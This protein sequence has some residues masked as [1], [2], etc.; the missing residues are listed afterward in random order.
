MVRF[1][2]PGS[3]KNPSCA[4]HGYTLI[5]T[6]IVLIIISLVMASLL[7]SFNLY[8]KTQERIKTTA[9]I[10]TAVQKIND[11]LVRNG[12]YPCP[13]PLGAS[14]SDA[15][16]GVSS[17][18]SVET[19]AVNT[20][21]TDGICI[22]EGENP[23]TTASSG[24]ICGTAGENGTVTL[25]PP[26]GMVFN[27]ITFASYGT[28][29][30]SCNS[31]SVGT[32]NATNSVTL[33][34]TQ[35]LNKTAGTSVSMVA[36]NGV[37]GDPCVGTSKSLYVQASYGLPGGPTAG[38]YLRV[39][40]GGL[41]FRTMGLDESYAEDG[42]GDRFV[43]AVT[44]R[45]ASTPDK[46]NKDGGAISVKDVNNRLIDNN[47][48]QVHYIVL[49]NG[50]DRAGSYTHDGKA[51][52]AC[53]ATAADGTNCQA[54][55]KAVYKA[56]DYSSTNKGVNDAFHYDDVIKF[57][58]ASTTP[59]WRVTADGTAIRDLV[60]AET[61]GKVGVRTS[62]PQQTVDTAGTVKTNDSFTTT[63]IC[64]NTGGNCITNGEIAKVDPSPS[65]K[66]NCDSD[67]TRPYASGFGADAVACQ[68]NAVTKCPLGSLM[69]GLNSD[70]TLI[71][72]SALTCASKQVNLCNIAGVTDKDTLPVALSGTVVP[73]KISGISYRQ[74]WK[75]GDDGNWAQQSATGICTCNLFDGDEDL[76]CPYGFTGTHIRH[77]VH[78][79]PADTDLITADVNLCVCT[80]TSK[81]DTLTCGT[82]YSS[83]SIT[84]KTPWVCDSLTAGHFGT[85]TVLSNT[86]TCTAQA[87]QSQ[88]SY[89]C[90][91]GYDG[92]YDQKRTW[93]C[94][95][96]GGAGSWSTWATISGG[97]HCT[98]TNNKPQTNDFPCP[99][100]QS[101]VDKQV[102]Y[103]N[104]ATDSWGPYTSYDNQC[105][106]NLY[107]W[108]MKTTTQT[109]STPLSIQEGTT[110]TT[111]GQTADC[112][113]AL[114]GGSGYQYGNCQCE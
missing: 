107:T 58:A 24:Y 6:S 45:L 28:P 42:Y 66:Y 89:T 14:R 83:G 41:P 34:A 17:D 90:P 80:P 18:C 5:E 109:N 69:Q 32:C 108:T 110:C 103:Y 106:V 74:T 38:T 30:G 46:Y 112:S 85:P 100:G 13:A 94:P 16:Y 65:T 97:N 43:Y 57:Y 99:T 82:G 31:Y 63:K 71:C 72:K 44:E 19:Q 70:G 40:T 35:F 50:P 52:L 36:S 87:A 96:S 7:T 104:C 111:S 113:R 81:T 48:G 2:R 21:T 10:N 23:V 27:G 25:T 4:Q 79:C 39:R 29:S 9:N 55:A 76:G 8:Y 1:V 67:V 51:S 62:T 101:G 75:C 49:S 86:C 64:D 33:A 54:G 60:S 78:L 12:H 20:C 102:R 53:S 61:S 26:T 84:Q 77:R 73:T 22:K 11:Y 98:C 92:Y 105:G 56:L 88:Q 37:F 114:S 59:L 3:N 47:A 91:P 95:T 93:T 15:S 68:Q